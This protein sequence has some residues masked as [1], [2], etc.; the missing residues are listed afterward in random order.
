MEKLTTEEI[1]KKINGWGDSDIY[2]RLEMYKSYY[3]AENPSLEKKVKDRQY[4]G[5][6]PNNF[7]P[8]AYYT[9]VIDSMAGYMFNHVQY[10]T[11]PAYTEL[12]NKTL[13]SNKQAIKDMKAG[14]QA[15][16][17]NRAVELVY[18]NKDAE[19]VFSNIDP[20]S[21][22]PVYDEEIEHNLF[23]GIWRRKSSNGDLVD[24]IY[25]D[26]WQYYTVEKGKLVLRDKPKK[27]FFSEC[28]IVIYDTQIIGSKPPFHQIIPYIDVLDWL[29]TG[30]SNEIERL[31]DALLVLGKSVSKED[32][33]HMDEWKAL[34]NYKTE[35]RAEYLTKD[36]T[37]SFREYVSKLLIQEIH[38]HSHVIDWYNPDTGISGTAS[39]KALKTRLF[40]M[41]MYSQR[42]EKIFREGTEKRINLIADI[43]KIK[44]K[45]IEPVEIEFKR[46]MINDFEEKILA[47]NQAAF[48]SVRTKIEESGLVWEEEEKRLDKEK[49]K[50]MESIPTMGDLYEIQAT[51]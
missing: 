20:L 51:E 29:I 41:D 37:P 44:G 46:D 25:S 47:L 19:P 12:L 31:V 8:T 10:K 24:V 6:T 27:L 13:K 7:V 21:L 17:Y 23:C 34:S 5:K 30:N 15:L 9:S 35:D 11:G 4:R 39:G 50:E 36:M 22:I 14:I 3:L 43:F 18:T 33:A 2:N 28:P 49:K 42:I 38:K 26:E 40:D 32:L 16:A 1:E 48:I 45:P